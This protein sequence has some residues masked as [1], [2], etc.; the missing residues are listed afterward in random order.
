MNIPYFLR[1]A[2][3]ILHYG[4][5]AC[6]VHAT[7]ILFYARISPPLPPMSSF[8][9]YFPMIEYTITS[10]ICVLFCGLICYYI[11]KKE[12]A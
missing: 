9:Y 11:A 4:L 1:L 10:F 12:G 2:R 8:Y 5:F 6:I 3:Q 7:M